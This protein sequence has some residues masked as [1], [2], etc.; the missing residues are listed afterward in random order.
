LDDDHIKKLKYIPP[1]KIKVGHMFEVEKYKANKK[2]KPISV[3]ESDGD[4]RKILADQDKRGGKLI[5]EKW[6]GY[7]KKPKK[8]FPYF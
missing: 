4:G 8:Y 2:G 6:I 3:F 1:K 7:C 5:E